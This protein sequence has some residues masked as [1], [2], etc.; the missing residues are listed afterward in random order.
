MMTGRTAVYSDHLW[1]GTTLVS[2]LPAAQV[3]N[4]RGLVEL[5]HPRRYSAGEA[6]CD[7]RSRTSGSWRE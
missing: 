4:R 5:P 6:T 1:L 3:Q 7:V 2:G